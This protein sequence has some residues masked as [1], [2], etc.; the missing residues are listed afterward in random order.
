MQGLFY[1]ITGLICV[2]APIE[3][4]IGIFIGALALNYILFME[5]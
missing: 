5:V 3:M 1:T 4:G 2:L